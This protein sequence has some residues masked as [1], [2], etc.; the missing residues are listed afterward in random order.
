M[1]KG[2]F[3]SE[4]IFLLVT[5][6]TLSFRS[7]PETVHFLEV[8]PPPLKELYS[9]EFYPGE[10]SIHFM[11][12][13]NINSSYFFYNVVKRPIS[14]CPYEYGNCFLLRKSYYKLHL[15]I[16]EKVVIVN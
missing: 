2:I 16:N 10:N 4:N 8:Q 11:K 7:N 3:I 13:E 6:V 5:L 1:L 12:K 14:N 15:T 9:K